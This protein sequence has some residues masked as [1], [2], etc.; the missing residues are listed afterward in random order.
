MGFIGNF[1]VGVHVCGGGCSNV[2]CLF[3]DAEGV[4]GFDCLVGEFCVRGCEGRRE[5]SG[6]LDFLN[7]AWIGLV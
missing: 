5:E 4:R 2:R 6:V 1:G 7:S 3:G